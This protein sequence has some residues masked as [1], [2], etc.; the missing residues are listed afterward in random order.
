MPGPDT[1]L[2]GRNGSLRYI[3]QQQH[4]GYCCHL[5]ALLNSLI[6]FGEEHPPVQG[7][8]WLQLLAITKCRYCSPEMWRV[9]EA[10]QALGLRM[11]EIPLELEEVEKNLPVMLPV[12]VNK[13]L[14]HASLAVEV[15]ED[16]LSL[17][18]YKGLY[19][20]SRVD[21]RRWD[22][23]WFWGQTGYAITRE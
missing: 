15:C 13:T 23:L 4:H 20:D 2:P 12:Y 1:A 3:Q 7:F 18:N 21:V 6:F 9:L 16:W 17:A 11:T 19:G 5:L 14:S 8:A 22:Q 10:A